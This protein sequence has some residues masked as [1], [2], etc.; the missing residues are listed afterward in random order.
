MKTNNI[1]IT[2]VVIV[3][4]LLAAWGLYYYFSKPSYQGTNN[5]QE[6]P[7]TD[8]NTNQPAVSSGSELMS[9]SQSLD[10]VN[11][12]QIDSELNQNNKDSTSFAPRIRDKNGNSTNWS[13]YAAETSLANPQSNSVSD[14][15]G[16]WV[17]P[18]VSCTSN[19]TYSSAWV[20][21]DG[22]SDSSVEQTG[23]EHDCINGLP[24]YYA[25][26]EMY[27]KPSYRINNFPVNAG[28]TINAEVKYTGGNK[29]QLT[30]QD[31]TTG[32]TFVTTQNA[33]ASRQS[34]EWVMEAPWSGGVLP[35]T[36]FGTINFSNSSATI[37]GVTGSINN[38][39][40]QNDPITMVNSSG[41]SKATPS[42][43][44]GDG[45]SFSVIWNAS[46]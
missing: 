12:G 3:V 39:L 25:W 22:Y 19:S 32:K 40:W 41:T 20:G 26:F 2:V 13:G 33:R 17:V 10:A 43:L 23:T 36:N 9:A 34:A 1:I 16:S 29:F 37:N 27:P 6:Q 21:I 8:Q 45:K 14:V 44:S 31:A 4:V 42:A 35:L 11:T 15:K 5:Y 46:N 7:T 28:D 24:S 38:T 30:L 18:A